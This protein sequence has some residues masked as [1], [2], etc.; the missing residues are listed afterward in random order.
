MLVTKYWAWHQI[1]SSDRLVAIQWIHIHSYITV[2]QCSYGLHSD[3][4]T[5]GIHAFQ[6]YA[7]YLEYS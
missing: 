5:L 4:N 1:S 7:P 3:A 2:Q 6:V